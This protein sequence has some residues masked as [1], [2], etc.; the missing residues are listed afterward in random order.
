MAIGRE[1]FER[2]GPFN[3]A[4]SG[5]GDEEDWLRRLTERGGK[6][7]YIANAAIDHRRVGDDARLRALMRSAF[8]RGYNLRG[9]DERE[10]KA[11]SLAREAR[12]LAGCGW[13]PLYANRETGP[14]DA[15]LRAIKVS[16]RMSV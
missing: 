1:A 8:Y 2:V 15:D 4:I 12:V 13:A 11:P 10:G 5:H 9:F 14:A 3:E 7:M 16:P 6:V